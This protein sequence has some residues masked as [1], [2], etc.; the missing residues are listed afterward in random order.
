MLAIFVR[1]WLQIKENLQVQSYSQMTNCHP[2]C[3]LIISGHSILHIMDHGLKIMSLSLFFQLKKKM[4]LGHYFQKSALAL[5]K[6]K[7]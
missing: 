1:F 3:L 6:V 2:S 7:R 5:L 4:L